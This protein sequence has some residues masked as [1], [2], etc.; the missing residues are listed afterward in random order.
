[1][2]VDVRA[3]AAAHDRI[4][5]GAGP[6]SKGARQSALEGPQTPR[7]SEIGDMN[8]PLGAEGEADDALFAPRRSGESRDEGP[9]AREQFEEFTRRR[10]NDS[11]H[12]H[13]VE[14]PARLVEVE[15]IGAQDLDIGESEGADPGRGLQ[16][17]SLEP[18]ERRD[19]SRELS[20]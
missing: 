20:E 13:L 15:P 19:L 5:P 6:R 11:M 16:R 14:A 8:R 18:L 3:S 17:Q 10:L 1:M 7:R 9:V 2:N 12:D 4:F